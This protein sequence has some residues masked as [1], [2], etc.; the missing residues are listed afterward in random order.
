MSTSLFSLPSLT[1][2]DNRSL[3]CLTPISPFYLL[4]FRRR[5]YRCISGLPGTLPVKRHAL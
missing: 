1:V 4:P 5:V 2:I 3:P